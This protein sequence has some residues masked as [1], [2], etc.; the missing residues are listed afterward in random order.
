MFDYPLLVQTASNREL[1]LHLLP[2]P[3]ASLSFL[4]L[5]LFLPLSRLLIPLKN[6]QSFR[7]ARLAYPSHAGARYRDHLLAVYP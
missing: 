3:L 7:Q 4:Y 2:L 1:F 6:Y 5:M